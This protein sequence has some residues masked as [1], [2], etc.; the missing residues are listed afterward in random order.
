M[1]W[2]GGTGIMH[3]RVCRELQKMPLNMN[4]VVL[5]FYFVN[6][7]ESLQGYPLWKRSVMGQSPTML[8]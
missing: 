7:L 1:N 5:C 6:K 2:G 4:D 8:F 3:L